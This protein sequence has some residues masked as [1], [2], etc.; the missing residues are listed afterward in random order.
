VFVVMDELE[1]VEN[2]KIYEA[3]EENNE[4]LP[5]LKTKRDILI[6]MQRLA[7]AVT[8]LHD[9]GFAHRVRG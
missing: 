3:C 8:F 6:F 2:R 9:N 7:E 5:F 1:E 4:R